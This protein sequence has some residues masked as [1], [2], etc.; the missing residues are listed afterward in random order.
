LRSLQASQLLQ[1]R[2]HIQ[3]LVRNGLFQADLSSTAKV[4][5]QTPEYGRRTGKVHRNL[6]NRLIGIQNKICGLSGLQTGI[7]GNILLKIHIE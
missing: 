3:P 2:L 1:H 4:Q 6:A 7:H 5:L